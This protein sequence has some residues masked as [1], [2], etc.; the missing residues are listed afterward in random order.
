MMHTFGNKRGSLVGVLQS[1]AAGGGHGTWIVGW[2]TSL[3]ILVAA[4]AITMAVRIRR[5][6]RSIRLH[7]DPESAHPQRRGSLASMMQS[8]S[9]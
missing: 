7:A 2:S 8:W 9:S 1:A 6:R 4:T 3:F 5:R